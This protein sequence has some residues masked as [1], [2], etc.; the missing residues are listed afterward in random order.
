[1]IAR[2]PYLNMEASLM[3]HVMSLHHL[4]QTTITNG[5]SFNMQITRY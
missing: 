2:E 4:M 1:M 3:V 5:T